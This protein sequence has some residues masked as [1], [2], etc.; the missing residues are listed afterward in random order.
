MSPVE[1]G[2]E[3]K[4]GDCDM[5]ARVCQKRVIFEAPIRLRLATRTKEEVVGLDVPVDG[6]QD[7]VSL[8]NREY[9]LGDVK[10]RHLFGEGVAVNEEGEQICRG[11]KGESGIMSIGESLPTAGRKGW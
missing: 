5:A 2:G 8:A 10:A 4:I 9:H 7:A 3:A 6:S 11:T 1:V